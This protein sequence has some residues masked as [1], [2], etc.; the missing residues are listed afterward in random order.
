MGAAKKPGGFDM[1]EPV[2][3]S[4]TPQ[5]ADNQRYDGLIDEMTDELT[6]I[7]SEKRRLPDR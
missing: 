3:C 7:S 6:V 1:T 4:V 2:R 5:F